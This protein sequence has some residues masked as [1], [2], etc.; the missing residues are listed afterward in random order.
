MVI[1]KVSNI[2]LNCKSFNLRQFF[3]HQFQEIPKLFDICPELFKD[4][5]I[6]CLEEPTIYHSFHVPMCDKNVDIKFNAHDAFLESLSCGTL[7]VESLK[8]K[9]FEDSWEQYNQLA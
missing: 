2:L 1:K 8:T 7:K 9:Y 5:C 4:I 3:R 6:E